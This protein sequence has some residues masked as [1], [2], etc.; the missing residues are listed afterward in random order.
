MNIS[1]LL[2]KLSNLANRAKELEVDFIVA[3][4]NYRVFS[5]NVLSIHC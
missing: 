3:I 5:N 4:N 1:D 2:E